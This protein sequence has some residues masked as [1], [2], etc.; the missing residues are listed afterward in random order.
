MDE[1]IDIKEVYTEKPCFCKRHPFMAFMFVSFMVFLGAFLAFYVVADWHF[2]RMFDPAVQM[3]QMD[4]MIQNDAR[5][6]DK[7]IQTQG[8]QIRRMEQKSENF[9]N[10]TREPDKYK[11]TVDLR[12]FDNNE[13][14]VEVTAKDNIL[15]I[16]AAGASNKRGHEKILKI[17]QN[18]MFDDDVNLKDITKTREGNELVIYVP[19][20]NT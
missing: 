16:N 1:N 2:K 5:R 20:D 14:N 19:S 3:R 4:R 17:S 18:Y 6:M 10:I 9:I 11:I 15:T 12:P 7:F 8:R 13:N